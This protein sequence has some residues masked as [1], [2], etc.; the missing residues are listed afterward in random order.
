MVYSSPSCSSN[1]FYKGDLTQFPGTLLTRE[2]S[3][4]VLTSLGSW[5][6]G[7]V[8]G[9]P[10]ST[11]LRSLPCGPFPG[12][13]DLWA[14]SG[15]RNVRGNWKR[16][17]GLTGSFSTEWHIHGPPAPSLI[18]LYDSFLISSIPSHSPWRQGQDLIKQNWLSASSAS[19]CGWT[20]ESKTC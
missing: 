8:G 1:V 17:T 9:S 18:T 4:Q 6:P 10:V 13:Q 20:V 11:G 3:F 2:G 14:S 19:T 16:L 15:G 12:L 5:T 7:P